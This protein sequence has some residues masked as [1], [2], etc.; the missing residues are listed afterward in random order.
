MELAIA[1]AD[2]VSQQRLAGEPE[3]AE[4]R[5]RVV[6]G[7]FDDHFAP[8]GAHWLVDHP[9][10]PIH[11]SNFRPDPF[12]VGRDSSTRTPCRLGFRCDVLGWFRGPVFSNPALLL[13]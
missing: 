4:H 6:G 3:R 2:V 7:E 5:Q 1:I 10:I 9:V 11:T 8:S 12:P 13:V